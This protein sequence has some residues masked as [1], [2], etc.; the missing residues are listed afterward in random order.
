MIKKISLMAAALVLAGCSSFSSDDEK[1]KTEPMEL[2]K[3]ETKAS[4]KRV[5]SYNAGDQGKHYGSL[6]ARLDAGVMYVANT[7]GEVA[8]VD[9][10][11]GKQQWRVE[12]QSRLSG[13]V[14]SDDSQVY[15]GSFAGNLIALDKENG[16]EIWR[17]GLSSEI[18]SPPVSNGSIVVAT[19]IDGKTYGLNASDG[20]EV[21]RFDTTLPLLTARGDSAPIIEGPLVLLGQSTGQVSALDVATGTVRWQATIAL[22]KGTSDLARMVDIDG[23]LLVE[24]GVMYAA[25]YQGQLMATDMA[26]GR[27]LWAQPA[28]TFHG[29]TAGFGNVYVAEADGRVVAYNTSNSTQAWQNENL[30][31]RGLGQPLAV[32]SYVLVS[33]FE[34]YVHMI[35]QVD[36]TLAGRQK[37]GSKVTTPMISGLGFVYILAN[38]GRLTAYEITQ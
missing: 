37:M 23:D 19:S 27:G 1:A 34:G 9:A 28:S 12:T 24:Q 18:I 38:D 2:E 20:S 26:S 14:G 7:D 21:W 4:L 10:Q 5:W 32:G 36:G 3:I 30:L 13:G 15:L 29:V 11:T 35:S 6:R 33:D 22:P 25:T 16:S 31:R 17:V 8:A